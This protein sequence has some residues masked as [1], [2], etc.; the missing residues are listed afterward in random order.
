MSF[1]SMDVLRTFSF[2]D[3]KKM[4]ESTPFDVMITK[5]N[6]QT[7]PMNVNNQ[8]IIE[9]VS[10]MF[11]QFLESIWGYHVVAIFTRRY[12]TNIDR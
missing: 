12:Q 8:S 10:R 4:V 5:T 2:H 6:T 1:K 7:S 11:F 3:E 9:D